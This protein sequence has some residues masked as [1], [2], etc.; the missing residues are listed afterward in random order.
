MCIAGYHNSHITRLWLEA[1]AN[2]KAVAPVLTPSNW[3]IP[4]LE[5]VECLQCEG[6]HYC[7]GTTYPQLQCPL[8]SYAPPGSTMCFRCPDNAQ[9]PENRLISTEAQC[10]CSSGFYSQNADGAPPCTACDAGLYK[11]VVNS[12]PKSSCKTCP[13]D[14]YSP[15]VNAS[16]SDTC[17]PCSLTGSLRPL[18]SPRGSTDASDC[19]SGVWLAVAN[20]GASKD[21]PTRVYR[22]DFEG[23]GSLDTRLRVPPRLPEEFDSDR[24]GRLAGA[25][26]VSWLQEKEWDWLWDEGK[27]EPGAV[28][29][30]STFEQLR[31]LRMKWDAAGG[32]YLYQ[33]A[34]KIQNGIG[35]AQALVKFRALL[36]DPVMLITL[37]T[38]ERKGK[39]F[40]FLQ[41]DE[42]EGRDVAFVSL[43]GDGGTFEGPNEHT[44]DF[45]VFQPSGTTGTWYLAVAQQRSQ[46]GTQVTSAAT[47]MVYRWK[48][49]AP[50]A[51]VNPTL[52]CGRLELIQSLPTYGATDFESFS[53]GS[54]TYVV[55]ASAT[56]AFNSSEPIRVF[57]VNVSAPINTGNFLQLHQVMHTAEARA[58]TPFSIDGG[59]YLAVAQ[60]RGA[61][62]MAGGVMAGALSHDINSPI[63]KW[64]MNARNG[65][66]AFHLLQTL[67]TRGARRWLHMSVRHAEDGM[68]IH[69]RHYLA[70]A[71]HYSQSTDVDSAIYRWDPATRQFESTAFQKFPTSAAADLAATELSA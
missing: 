17:I 1:Q 24:H 5:D 33:A 12:L 30:V 44:S 7:L 4:E 68:P 46:S 41:A 52:D 49:G 63:Y 62:T 8:N 19:I 26:R 31:V 20:M 18:T 10:V 25:M 56:D 2:I 53:I 51:C 28:L 6:G 40:T 64:D 22:W 27:Q 42:A 66:G 39:I 32:A 50:G 34:Q 55:L 58:V 45:H 69:T 43:R 37:Q 23:A 13:P 48:P 35:Q 36:N 70:V 67:P 11:D 29:L 65:M 16:S 9:Q 3:I 71:N 14:T 21:R 15:S 60:W 57:R 38:D 47:S 59:T 54:E 61:G